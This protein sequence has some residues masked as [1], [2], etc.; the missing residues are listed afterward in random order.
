MNA[1]IEKGSKIAEEQKKKVMSSLLD[2]SLASKQKGDAK[3]KLTKAIVD[4]ATKTEEAA[5][6]MDAASTI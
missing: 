4:Q 1:M 5:P 6:S 3:T 2:A